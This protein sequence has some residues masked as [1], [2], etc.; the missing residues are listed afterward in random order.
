MNRQE[1]IDV[2]ASDAK[3]TKTT[4]DRV[5]DS[6]I[7]RVKESVIKGEPVKLAGFGTFELTRVAARRGWNPKTG[8]LVQIESKGRPRFN[9]STHFKGCIKG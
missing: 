8:E 1:L 9:P 7:R 2:I 3:I 6:F 4:A 5:L